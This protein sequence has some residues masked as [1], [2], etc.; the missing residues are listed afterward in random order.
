MPEIKNLN[1]MSI[2]LS[3]SRTAWTNTQQSPERKTRRQDTE[4]CIIVIH[5][6]FDPLEIVDDS[7]VEAVFPFG[8]T[9]DAPA[10]DTRD[11]VAPLGP[12]G[13]RAAAVPLARVAAAVRLPGA[14]HVV[15]QIAG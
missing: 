12:G 1:V 10:D 5:C 11:R 2:L 3:V 13:Q 8:V 7:G 15:G 4:L 14:H 9:G 6:I